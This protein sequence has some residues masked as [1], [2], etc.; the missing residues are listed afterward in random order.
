MQRPN[1]KKI[2]EA[3][4]K[5]KEELTKAVAKAITKSDNNLVSKKGNKTLFNKLDIPKTVV[6]KEEIL[7]EP[8]KEEI[9]TKPKKQVV[10]S[11]TN[12]R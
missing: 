5:K 8:K 4:E 10:K 3:I 1:S 12:L 2:P 6:K 7:E 9:P 11:V